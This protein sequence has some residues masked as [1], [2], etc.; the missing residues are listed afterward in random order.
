MTT[1]LNDIRVLELGHALAGPFASVMM[2]DFGA[3]IIKIERPGVGDSLRSMGPQRGGKG[4]WWTVTGRN[5]R[6]VCIDIKTP[7]GLELVRELVAVSDVVVENFRPGV[8]E[9]LGLGYDDL[10]AVKPDLIMLRVSGFGQTGPYSHRG[11]FG[12][13]AEA[14]SGATHLTGPADDVPVHPGYSL[15]DAATGLMGAYGIMVALHHR[16]RTGRG[17][18]ID[19]ALYEPLLRM[20]EWQVP[21]HDASGTSPMR[22]GPRFPF[23]GAFITDI[24]RTEDGE[25]IVVSAATTQSLTSLRRLLVDAGMLADMAAGEGDV[26]DAL[27]AW[28]LRHTRDTALKALHDANV[29]AGEIYTAADIGQ[30]PHMAARRNLVTVEDNGH[31]VRMPGVIPQMTDSPGRVAWA[32]QDLGAQTDDVLRGVLALD[33]DRIARL[34]D[35]GVVS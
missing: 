4:I 6:S 19:L 2:G 27:R 26:V 15:G 28:T 17:Q 3:D 9:R 12:K 13:I 11:G 8:L 22:N 29:V 23:D 16:D 24:C 21:I 1:P 32:G 30:D 14:F 10:C 33:D 20:I 35:T 18:Q 31:E 7:E 34:H 5:K 25:G